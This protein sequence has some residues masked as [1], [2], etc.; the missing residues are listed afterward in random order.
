MPPQAHQTDD[1]IA[2]V[3]TFIRNSFGNKASAVT[4]EQVA[5]LRSEVG[6]PMITSA[7]LTLPVAPVAAAP[8]SGDATAAAITAPIVLSLSDRI[9]LP[10]W[11]V[12]LFGLW[13]VVC[14]GAAFKLRS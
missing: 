14:L 7:E 11:A 3:L 5:A 4:A 13:A 2:A 1:Q 6:K 12:G 10:L 8:A 9:G